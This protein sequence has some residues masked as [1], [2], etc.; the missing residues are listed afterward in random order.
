MSAVPPPRRLQLSSDG[1]PWQGLADEVTVGVL[2][3]ELAEAV[4]AVVTMQHAIGAD[5]N[6]VLT[7]LR[8]LV[9]GKVEP[10]NKLVASAVAG[11]GA[12]GM[13]AHVYETF[14]KQVLVEVHDLLLQLT[15]PDQVCMVL[16]L[17]EMHF[18]RDAP[19]IQTI[20][21]YM[22]AI[23]QLCCTEGAVT[24]RLPDLTVQG[25]ALWQLLERAATPVR[26]AGH[27]AFLKER[28]AAK[29]AAGASSSLLSFAAVRGGHA[30][31]G[32]SSARSSSSHAKSTS[33]H[34][35]PSEASSPG[36]AKP[37]KRRSGGSA[38]GCE[39]PRQDTDIAESLDP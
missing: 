28:D 6:T 22:R 5:R 10:A 27:T 3:Q 31:S 29:Q 16:R 36:E 37:H 4:E 8:R 26:S 12:H 13:V 15:R 32:S 30:L 11:G 24:V 7:M 21:Q 19:D 34:G 23:H 39:G 17:L 9:V 25:M 18:T 2:N 1:P 33:S 20:E 38:Q 14:D 35:P